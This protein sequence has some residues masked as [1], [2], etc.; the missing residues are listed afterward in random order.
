MSRRSWVMLTLV[1]LMLVSLPLVASL[2]HEAC[3]AWTAGYRCGCD[4]CSESSE[5]RV[6]VELD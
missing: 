6:E 1:G 5:L 3:G 2:H 4:T